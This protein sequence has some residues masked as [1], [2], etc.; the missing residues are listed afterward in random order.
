MRYRN[1]HYFYKSNTKTILCWSGEYTVKYLVFESEFTGTHYVF[2]NIEN[3]RSWTNEIAYAES[4][5][6]L[7]SFKNGF[8]MKIPS[9][10]RHGYCQVNQVHKRQNVILMKVD[11]V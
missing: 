1:Y 7:L 10:E 8:I 4:F 3:V 2:F 5:A 6:F 9:D 11:A